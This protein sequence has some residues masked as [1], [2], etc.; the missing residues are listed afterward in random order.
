[1]KLLAITPNFPPAPYGIRMGYFCRYLAGCGWSPYVVC[2][3]RDGFLYPGYEMFV[4]RQIDID[5]PLGGLA[6]RIGRFIIPELFRCH[7]ITR[8]IVETV[9]TQ[10]NES[11]FD[12]ILASIG[13]YGYTPWLAA[14][15]ILSERWG[16][17]WVM[18]LRDIAEQVEA[19]S[20][21]QRLSR[22]RYVAV[23]N[24]L[25][26]R[27]SLI[28]TVSPWHVS[29]LSQS[30]STSV[31]LIYNGYDPSVFEVGAQPVRAPHFVLLYAG[32]IGGRAY[33][34]RTF[35]LACDKLLA[36]GCV[37]R[38]DLR[39]VIYTP[40]HA[41]RAQF[42]RYACRDCVHVHDSVPHSDIPYLM[43]TASVLLL[44]TAESA[45][46][47][48]T[49]KSFEYAASRRPVLCMPASD[50]NLNSF[51]RETGSGVCTSDIGEAV[52]FVAEKY[53]EW[54]K[55]GAVA[56]MPSNETLL[57]YSRERQSRKME[58]LLR[59]VLEGGQCIGT[60]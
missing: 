47:C 36:A 39:I 34:L 4:S 40:S 8:R 25:L 56:N 51:I 32:T 45:R 41:E 42:S 50:P 31:E 3:R 57:E 11:R 29:F 53:K 49:T 12:I 22:L 16:I 2:Q 7:E 30:T 19:S 37:A 48:M 6:R 35:M 33:G 38:E 20:M 28:T 21:K 1:M 59:R 24:H 9:T 27:A 43:R 5:I 14:A 13:S 26:R 60:E 55:T 10:W 15:S 46:G 17:P 58:I 18:D 52:T 54:K 44:F 23:R